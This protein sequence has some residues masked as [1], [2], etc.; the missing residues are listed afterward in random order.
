M[1]GAKTYKTPKEDKTHYYTLMI[2]KSE[3][4]REIYYQ[5]QWASQGRDDW[6]TVVREMGRYCKLK[7][8]EQQ[9]LF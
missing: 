4:S 6:Q 1:W 3:T 5:T 7:K 9:R 2:A 8:V